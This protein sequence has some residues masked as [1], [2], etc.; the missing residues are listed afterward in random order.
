[1]EGLVRFEVSSFRQC[2]FGVGS[3]EDE[4]QTAISYGQPGGGIAFGGSQHGA[5]LGR[6]GQ[7]HRVSPPGQ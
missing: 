5:C 1:M 6:G 7:A 4:K 2:S 3:F